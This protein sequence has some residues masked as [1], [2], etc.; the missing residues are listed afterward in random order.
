MDPYVTL[1]I[2]P[3]ANEDE[4]KKAFRMEAMKWHPDRA[5]DSGEAKER[6]LE[7]SLA[8]QFLSRQFKTKTRPQGSRNGSVSDAGPAVQDD[9]FRK[10]IIEYAVGLVQAGVSRKEIRTRLSERGCDEDLAAAIAD[11]AFNFQHGFKHKSND[12][13]RKE[14]D[15]SGF[16]KRKFDYQ[17]IQA[18]LGKQN[19]D[20]ATRKMISDYHE[21]FNELN[22]KDEAGAIFPTS[23]NRYL[24]KVFSRSILLFLIIA[25]MMYF[26]PDLASYVPLGTIDFFQL[27]N[28]ILSL[29]LVWSA[30]KRIWLLTLFSATV[31]ALSQMFYYTSM[32]A[33]LEHDFNT[34]LVTSMA[35]YLPFLLVAHLSN[36]FYYKKAKHIIESVDHLYPQLEDK[37]ILVRHRGGVSRLSALVSMLLLSLYFLHMIP[38][39]GSLDNKYSSLFADDIKIG[40]REIRQ[41]VA[42]ISKSE[43]LFLRAE[44]HFNRSPPDYRNAL[45]AYLQSSSAGSLLSSYKLGYMYF[46]GK[47]VTQDDKTAFH[48][49]NRAIQSPLA[50]QPHSLSM[51]TRWLNESYK[52]LGIMYLG[53]FGTGRDPQ[54]ARATFRQALKYGASIR[55][56]H[57]MQLNTYNSRN[58]RALVSPPEYSY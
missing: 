24:S 5:G 14:Q 17:S 19:P 41:N 6:F 3:N 12:K 40:S 21:A 52:S 31:F 30:Y 8:Y 55:I 39:S 57:L 48:Y 7:I 4:L 29:M 54:K 11:Q 56:N 49:F 34:A 44:E 58:L 16:S 9:E 20:D 13:S 2:S 46:V 33:A 36:F 51:A 43:Q 22:E 38:Q 25:A 50:S 32:P 28:I 27:P 45:K 47:G 1:G 15:S 53:G 37:H 10:L 23:K 42:R 35:C 18:L 26:F